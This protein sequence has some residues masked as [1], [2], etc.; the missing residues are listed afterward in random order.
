MLKELSK[1]GPKAYHAI[2]QAVIPP[3]RSRI[4]VFPHEHST[5]TNEGYWYAKGFTTRRNP[6]EYW[7]FVKVSCILRIISTNF[8]V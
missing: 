4:L 6:H 3:R 7:G 5:S 1:D 2:I 8:T